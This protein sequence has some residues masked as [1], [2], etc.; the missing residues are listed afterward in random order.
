MTADPWGERTVPAETAT[1]MLWLMALAERRPER[2]ETIQAAAAKCADAVAGTEKQDREIL[3]LGSTYREPSEW[4]G[5]TFGWLF[6]T[7]GAEWAEAVLTWH[8]G[9][10]DFIHAIGS[11][12]GRLSGYSHGGHPPV[13]RELTTFERLWTQAAN[14]VQWKKA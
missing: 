5:T 9:S 3:L 6:E 2:R 14:E 11:Y 8:T 13:L 10:F 12:R 1:W 7:N 4:H